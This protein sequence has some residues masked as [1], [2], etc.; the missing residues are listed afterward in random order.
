M[1]HIIGNAPRQRSC[2]NAAVED[3]GSN[4]EDTEAEEAEWEDILATMADAEGDRVE[5]TDDERDTVLLDRA[6]ERFTRSG[7][8]VKRP[9]SSKSITHYFNTQFL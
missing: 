4:S 3:S 6:V 1:N 2:R 7:M 9:K 8:R 5:V